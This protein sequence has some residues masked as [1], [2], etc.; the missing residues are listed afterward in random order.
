MP[1]VRVLFAVLLF[2][3]SV[4]QAAGK[5]R[6]EVG[7]AVNSFSLKA[8]NT[9]ESGMGWVRLDDFVGDKAKTRKK[10]VLLTFFATYCEPCKREMPFVE[11]LYRQYKDAGL[12]VVSVSIDKED[13]DLDIVKKLIKKH[14][15]TFPVISD[16]FNIVAKR[17]FISK[18]PC[19]YLVDTDGKVAMVNVGYSDDISKKLLDQIR[20]ALGE[21][22]DAPIPPEIAAHM[23][24]PKT[25]TAHADGNEHQG[26]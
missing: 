17:Y 26:E 16:R 9:A 7:E 11:A 14:G 15:V 4:A 5:D 3:S 25:A 8:L 13:K 19:V 18:L 1:V 20:T 6:Y 12:M 22:L 2:A 10:A 23:T 24:S 21:P